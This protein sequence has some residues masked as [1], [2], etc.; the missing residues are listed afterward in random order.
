LHYGLGKTLYSHFTSPIRRYSDLLLHQQLWAADT[1]HA[2]KSNKT[3]QRWGVT[4][5]EL[6]NNNDEAYYAASTRMKIRYLEE[7]LLAG[8][9]NVFSAMITRVTNSGAVIELPELGLQGF[10]NA[11]DLPGGYRSEEKALQECHVG[12]MLTVALDDIDFVKAA[13]TFRA[14]NIIPKDAAK[15]LIHGKN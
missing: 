12:K 2:L 15:K 14:V 1:H 11:S 3:M 4:L 5:S 13:A 7:M 9:E 10:V 8:R 6:E